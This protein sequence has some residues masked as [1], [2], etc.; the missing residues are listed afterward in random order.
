MI[1]PANP[2]LARRANAPNGRASAFCAAG[3]DFDRAK[4]ICVRLWLYRG[5]VYTMYHQVKERRR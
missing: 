1:V 5:Q 4:R 2:W 3:Y